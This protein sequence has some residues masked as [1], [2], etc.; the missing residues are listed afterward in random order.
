MLLPN[1]LTIEQW[2]HAINYFNGC[3]AVCGRPLENL[4]GDIKPAIDH[5]IPL[6][7]KGNDNPGTVATNIVPLCHGDIGSCNLNKSNKMPG[8]WLNHRFGKYKAKKISK[9][10]QDYFDS[11][12]QE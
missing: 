1:I 3:C 2:Q 5:W 11:L 4:F 10:I 9:R 6:T 12:A 8:E 7:Y